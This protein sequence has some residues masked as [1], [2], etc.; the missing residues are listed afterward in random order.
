MIDGQRLVT[1]CPAGRQR[2]LEILVPYL[3]RER[4]IIDRHDFWLN[5]SVASD[6]E[7]I[8]G[9]AKQYPD[10]FRVVRVPN[11]GFTPRGK[12]KLGLAFHIGTFYPHAADP[13][14]V[15][16]RLDD[17]IVYVSPGGIEALARYRLQHPT[18]FLVYPTIINN[19]I[20]THYLQADGVFGRERGS[21]DYALKG[22][23]LS[24][25]RLAEH[26][27]RKFL[28]AVKRGEGE[29][30]RVKPRTVTDYM[31]VSVNCMSWLGRDLA[32]CAAD[33]GDY[34]EEYL[35]TTR[36]TALGRPNVIVDV[37][38]VA[39]FSYGEQ[40]SYLERTNLLSEYR[41]LIIR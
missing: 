18:P 10:F 21:A 29:R 20:L 6:I 41:R 11:S 39:H 33:V 37:A 5:T 35:A 14:T 15:Y 9:L 25:G 1:V 30:W 31:T 3:L 4:G 40:R 24:D 23:G 7:Y 19:S 28:A 13:E 12:P 26:L 22:R 8:D 38:T 16:V 2:F 17:D 32:A 36:P 34:E 27:H